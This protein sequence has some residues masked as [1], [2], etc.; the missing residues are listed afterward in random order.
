[1]TLA[2]SLGS[3]QRTFQVIKVEGEDPE[4]GDDDID[5]VEEITVNEITTYTIDGA[6]I[7][8]F[9]KNGNYNITVHTVAGQKVAETDAE[10]NAGENVQ[11]AINAQGTYILTVKKDGNVVRSV[12]LMSK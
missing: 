1:M 6:A 12:K 4:Q 7:I 11:I 8:E 9:A 2:N 3:D 10:I 5:G